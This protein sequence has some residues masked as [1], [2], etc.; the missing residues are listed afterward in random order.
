MR[1]LSWATHIL[2][3]RAARQTGPAQIHLAARASV[4]QSLE[5]FHAM[6][7]LQIRV[8][9]ACWECRL[10]LGQHRGH[11]LGHLDLHEL[12]QR[13]CVSETLARVRTSLMFL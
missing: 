1:L 3:L 2:A 7:E 5:L 10:A 6:L 9:Q 11:R 13:H 12:Q 8:D 4:M